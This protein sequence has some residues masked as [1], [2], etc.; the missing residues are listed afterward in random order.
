MAQQDFDQSG[1]ILKKL[2][3]QKTLDSS[4]TLMSD[5]PE[6]LDLFISNIHGHWYRVKIH[7]FN[8]LPAR[9]IKFSFFLLLFFLSFSLLF[10]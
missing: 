4:L 7:S 6:F 5:I 9:R 10:P 2:V 1:K 8:F 3:A